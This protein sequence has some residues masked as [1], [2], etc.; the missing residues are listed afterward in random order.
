MLNLLYSRHTAGVAFPRWAPCEAATVGLLRQRL[1]RRARPRYAIPRGTQLLRGTLAWGATPQSWQFPNP[2]R[3]SLVE[4][5]STAGLESSVAVKQKF[6]FTMGVSAL[7]I[8][9]TIPR[10]PRPTHVRLVVIC[11]APQLVTAV[12]ERAVSPRQN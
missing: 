5:V 4:E 12:R 9:Q 10:K 11:R 1:L 6:Y 3:L 7:V 2:C 8:F